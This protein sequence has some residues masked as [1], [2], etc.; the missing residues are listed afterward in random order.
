CSAAATGDVGSTT[1]AS[2]GS[3]ESVGSVG[4]AMACS[5]AWGFQPSE[6]DLGRERR[7]PP[8]TRG[9]SLWFRY[10]AARLL[11]PRVRYAAARLL[12]PRGWGSAVGAGLE[13][14]RAEAVEVD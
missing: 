8:L 12:N 7:R 3:D 10:A 6:H 11:N 4:W 2:T 13:V 1:S 9:P 5:F 14:V